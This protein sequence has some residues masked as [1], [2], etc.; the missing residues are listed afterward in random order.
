[1]AMRCALTS[2]PA[3]LRSAAAPA[4][5]R[6]FSDGKGRVLSE[7]ERAKESVYIQKMERE[8]L[9]KLKK[10]QEQEKADAEKAGK[11]PEE[12]SK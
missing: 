6:A 9:E 12:G 7:E 10:K 1:M 2:L 11:K 3:R 8:R 5:V 4:A